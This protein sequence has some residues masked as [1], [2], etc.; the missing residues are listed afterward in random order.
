MHREASR[1]DPRDLA[2]QLITS[3]RYKFFYNGPRIRELLQQLIVR[4]VAKLCSETGW[5]WVKPCSSTGLLPKQLLPHVVSTNPYGPMKSSEALNYTLR[6]VAGLKPDTNTVQFDSL[7]D[8]V[9]GTT[10]AL[11]ILFVDDFIGIGRQ[12]SGRLVA[13]LGSNSALMDAI[14]NKV[15]RGIPIRLYLLVCVAFAEGLQVVKD[16]LPD[17]LPMDILAGEVLGPEAKV[18]SN[19]SLVFPERETR[20]E[21]EL[22]MVDRIGRYLYPPAPAG[23]GDMQSAVVFEHNTP[24]DS[25]PVLWKEGYVDRVSWKPLFPRAGVA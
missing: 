3:V 17:W 9:K 6:V 20:R 2:E 25:L 14:K 24:N 5:S 10:K 7:A 8:R 15:G 19:E 16:S 23:F 12:A 22:L 11:L 13:G 1:V 18:F 21:A 4:L